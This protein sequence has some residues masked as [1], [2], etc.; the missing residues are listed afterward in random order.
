MPFYGDDFFSAMVGK[1]NEVI[2]AYMRAIWHYW[3]HRQCRG[4]R[5]D[6]ESLRQICMV[7]D[8]AKWPAIKAVVFGELFEMDEDGLW[9]QK[10]A[11]EEYTKSK[12]RYDALVDYGK[13]GGHAS[14]MKRKSNRGIS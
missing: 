8:S 7:F 10:R 3:R 12:A 5:D 13:R 14:W 11:Q 6:D 2:V 4:L 9:H 1:S